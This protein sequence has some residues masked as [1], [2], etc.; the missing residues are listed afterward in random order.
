[1]AIALQYCYIISGETFEL[2][3]DLAPSQVLV[4]MLGA[5]IN[6]SDIN[7]I[8]GSSTLLSCLYVIMMDYRIVSYSKG[9]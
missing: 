5:P 7:Q 8:E 9:D 6:P 3:T 4:K 1:M 2:S